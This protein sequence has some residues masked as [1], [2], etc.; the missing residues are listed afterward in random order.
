MQAENKE[1]HGKDEE[2]KAN[3]RRWQNERSELNMC[4]ARLE[5]ELAH[6]RETAELA[7]GHSVAEIQQLKTL[8]A[9]DGGKHSAEFEAMKEREQQ[10]KEQLGEVIKSKQ[11]A[12]ATADDLRSRLKEVQDLSQIR[13]AELNTTL[14]LLQSRLSE[15][16]ESLA[17]AGRQR[18]ES[19]SGAGKQVEELR[20]E[21][22][23][24]DASIEQLQDQLRDKAA[25]VGHTVTQMECLRAC[26][27]RCEK[28]IGQ[29]LDES[30]SLPK[31][32]SRQSLGIW[33]DESGILNDDASLSMLADEDDDIQGSV[34][35]DR[36]E[37]QLNSLLQAKSSLEREAQEGSAEVEQ[38]KHQLQES[39]TE[40][41]RLEEEMLASEEKAALLAQERLASETQVKKLMNENESVWQPE[42]LSLEARVAQLQ[43]SEQSM[44]AMREEQKKS[45]AQMQ[46]DRSRN[47]K[48]SA[49]LHAQVKELQQEKDAIAGKLE[50][51][52]SRALNALREKETLH[53][54]KK[55]LEREVLRFCKERDTMQ[56]SLDKVEGSKS[57]EVRA[58]R[59]EMGE[60]SHEME[61][62]RV[63]ISTLKNEVTRLK[64]ARDDAQGALELQ[65]RTEDGWKV[66]RTRL[67]NEVVTL[68]QEREVERRALEL[69]EIEN[70]RNQTHIKSLEMSRELARGGGINDLEELKDQLKRSQ[71]DLDEALT[72]RDLS[73]AKYQRL[74]DSYEVLKRE[75]KELESRPSSLASSTAATTATATALAEERHNTQRLMDGIQQL[76]KQVEQRDGLIASLRENATAIVQVER[77]GI[78][79]RRRHQGVTEGY[80]T[81]P[82]IFD[83]VASPAIDLSDHATL[84]SELSDGMDRLMHFIRPCTELVERSDDMIQTYNAA[85]KSYAQSGLAPRAGLSAKLGD[86]CY[87]LLDSN[88]QLVLQMQQLGLDLKRVYRRF[89]VLEKDS[90]D[91][92][93][94][95]QEHLAEVR[96]TV[97]RL[98][99]VMNQQQSGTDPTCLENMAT[100]LNEVAGSLAMAR[101][102]PD[103]PKQTKDPSRDP[104]KHQHQHQQHEYS[105]YAKSLA[106]VNQVTQ[107]SR[108]RS[109]KARDQSLDRV[110]AT[111]S[112]SSRRGKENLH[113]KHHGRSTDPLSLIGLELERVGHKASEFS[114][115]AGSLE[116]QLKPMRHSSR[117]PSPLRS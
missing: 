80:G 86:D 65:Q 22:A 84:L 99:N 117:S 40:L 114:M 6:S 108:G 20:Q 14:E 53:N 111:A 39:Q 48:E 79:S 60:I 75:V 41:K 100:Q 85:L 23:L 63:E 25:Q 95:T 116:H 56:G 47:M 98:C 36:L 52:V 32:E 55:N 78:S 8:L 35:L 54:E 92:T 73:N 102:K 57:E 27:K 43:Q 82:G 105:Y 13:E 67:E 109:N 49:L 113:S 70:E 16:R 19:Q 37:N 29:S 64:E 93:R 1:A 71:A 81:S 34:S 2:L 24:R 26:V 88:A 18:A 97:K 110:A 68:R 11:L 17:E 91:N 51:E 42:K 33:D 58:L 72:Q 28:T 46:K 4:L 90:A 103:Y 3:E 107:S 5:Q 66:E 38:L 9:Q 87:N 112:A 61:M 94:V 101:R 106:G 12:Q 96:Y 7:A 31:K 104:T 115:I 15:A 77:E 45:L 10:Q 59:D 50:M 44:A 62:K 76:K 21:L 83:E 89:K 30:L 74:E 69:K